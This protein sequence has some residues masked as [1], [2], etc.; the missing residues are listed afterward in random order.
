MFGND[1]ENFPLSVT[2]AGRCRLCADSSFFTLTVAIAGSLVQLSG[3]EL[4]EEHHGQSSSFKPP[5]VVWSDLGGVGAG[6]KRSKYP[7]FLSVFSPKH[8]QLER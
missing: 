1:L 6:R 5:T 8:P 2:V 7:F 3:A 4:E